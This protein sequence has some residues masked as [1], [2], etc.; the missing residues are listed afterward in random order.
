MAVTGG[1]E[2]KMPQWDDRGGRPLSRFLAADH[3]RLDALFQQAMSDPSRI[4]GT[5]YDRFRAGS[6][7]ISEWRKR[8]FCRRP[9]D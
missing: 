6:C 3:R 1:E 7:G 5:A 8:F 4:D 9:N 2:L